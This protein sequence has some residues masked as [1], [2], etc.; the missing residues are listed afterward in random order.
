MFVDIAAVAESH[1]HNKQHIVRLGVDD[2]VVPDPDSVSRSTAEG[3]GRGWA[4]VLGE[5]RI[6]SLSDRELRKPASL[7]ASVSVARVTIVICPP[8][9]RK[10]N[11]GPAFGTRWLSQVITPG[12]IQSLRSCRTSRSRLA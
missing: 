9:S 11:R 10:K 12:S 7:S 8:A 4:R 1:D 6:F 3:P 2:S 5:Q